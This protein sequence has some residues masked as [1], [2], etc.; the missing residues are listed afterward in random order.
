MESKY[1]IRN[2][3]RIIITTVKQI[4]HSF[5]STII[6]KIAISLILLYYTF[7]VFN[8]YFSYELFFSE[9]VV[10][11]CSLIKLENI[12]YIPKYIIYETYDV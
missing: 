9:N 8:I 7:S 1:N 6:K 3:C 11:A 2:K 12:D 4:D 10:K 5:I